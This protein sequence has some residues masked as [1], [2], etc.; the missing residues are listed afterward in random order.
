MARV[1][2]LAI[3][4][5][6][7]GFPMFEGWLSPTYAEDG[8]RLT[9]NHPP[10]AETFTSL[11]DAAP[12]LSLQ[13]QIRFAVRHQK[14]LDQL[15]ADQQNR[16]SSR[17]HKWLKKG[18][19]FRRF[20]PSSSEVKALEAW[21][22]GE[23]FTIASRE[24]AYLAFSGSVAQAEHTFDTRIARF[25]AGSTYANTSDPVIPARFANVIGAILGMDNMVHAVPVSHQ[26]A[27][28]WK[29][30]EHASSARQSPIELAQAERA[31]SETSGG[32]PIGDVIIGGIEA[33]GPSDVRTFYDETVGTGSDGTGD[34]IAIVGISDFLDSAMSAFT[35]QFGLP[36][37]NYTREVYGTNPGIVS[38]AEPEAELDL[39]WSHAAAPGA[40]IVYHLGSDLIGDI[41]GAVSD[42]ACGAISI[43]YSFCDPS[44]SL[45]EGTL[46][47]IF[48]QAALQGQSVFVSAGDDGA[49]GLN[50]SC[51]VNNTRSVNEMS[52]D[53]N[54]TSVGGTQF[55]PSYS[56]GGNDVGH[57][58][59][60]VWNDSSGSG[61]GG[62]SQ[63]FS[64]PAYQTGS[65][66]PNDGAR[67]VPDVALI[68]SPNSP[69]VFWGHDESG[70]GAIACCIGGT[71]LSAPLWA[72]FSRVI[73]ER[74]GSTRLGNL[75]SV[76]YGLANSN[77]NSA[78]F[79]DITSGNNS[80][81]GV[82]GFSAGPG[83]DQASGWGT[84]DFDTFATSAETWIAS[85]PS[86]TATATATR[87]AIA[88]VTPTAT[89]TATATSTPT[90][91]ATA[92]ATPTVTATLTSTATPTA[93][94]TATNTPTVTATITATRTATS[95]ATPTATLTAT[96]T[97]T[98]TATATLTST[99][100]ATAT[101]TATA[102][103]TATLLAT[104]T[105][106]AT[107]T[108]IATAT[109]TQTAVA[110]A[111]ATITPTMTATRTATATSTST[112]TGT[113]TPTATATLTSTA[114]PSATLTPTA[115]ST[116]TA[117]AIATPTVTQTAFPTATLTVT[118]TATQPATPSPTATMNP[119]ATATITA[120]ATAMPT[121][122]PTLVPTPPTPTPV[123]EPTGGV[124]SAPAAIRFPALG[125]GMPATSRTVLI[126]N[127]SRTSTLA[128][129]VGSLSSPF[130]VSGA[131][132]YSLAP[133]SSVPVT[134]MFSPEVVG[135]ASQA[136]PITSG[137]PKHPHVN[138]TVSGMVQ[139]GKLSV[140]RTISLAAR[141]GAMA[142]RTV[143]LRNSGR[144][145]L[146]G[147]VES[148][149]Q[150]SPFT[151]E[152]GPV[153]FTLAPGQTQPISIQFAPATSGSITANL[154]IETTPPP[155]TM[156]VV[157]HGSAR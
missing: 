120:T 53:P 85:H 48:E 60:S 95:T 16:A 144:G 46:D 152:S 71:S 78:G 77:Y 27:P 97:Q 126:R 139:P 26:S 102:T 49:A 42:N 24:P 13:M 81:D 39:Q 43:S 61:G 157:V 91:T 29:S 67:D 103:S 154:T 124:L 38:A 52:A 98:P 111:T 55:S 140:S 64:K 87:T 82:T 41:G 32:S 6:A 25:G 30:T 129:E 10:Q 96:V 28:F 156:T 88:T 115:T 125:V 40:S 101:L 106:T 20:G 142:T 108:S 17:Y 15:L 80:F 11:G 89:R 7:V 51:G 65:G 66:V 58:S 35:N 54:V 44:A 93:T 31:D 73:A 4:L 74:A 134:V 84:I 18:E 128:L 12:N 69:G 1:F 100:S 90:T 123:S 2:A 153:P 14:A 83:Y 36:A 47:P 23:G 37:I 21:L 109:S 147:T 68:A 105:A 138:I 75:N 118:S 150:G 135:M 50:S 107:S 112:T 56:G 145:M 136:L 99:P 86:A 19:F 76:I 113:A 59:E 9:G 8:V 148:F 131:G 137:D 151:L 110:T 121:S 70:T 132:N 92:T 143:T 33:F 34:C 5:C 79:H 117:T 94:S 114:T 122:M 3:G 133:G 130:S 104:P 72:G 22:I 119:T 146:S 63:Y 149:D 45:I 62:A 141:P 57:S 155:A 127:A 116:A